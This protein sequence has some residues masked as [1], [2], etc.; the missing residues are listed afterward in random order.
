MLTLEDFIK[1]E[2]KIS[3]RDFDNS[4]IQDSNRGDIK[5]Y[6]FVDE[7]DEFDVLNSR[8]VNKE[9]QYCFI[10]D[11][12]INTFKFDTKIDYKL[13]DKFLWVLFA[14]DQKDIH[15][16]YSKWNTLEYALDVNSIVLNSRE[17]FGRK[18]YFIASGELKCMENMR[19]IKIF[20]KK[21]NNI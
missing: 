18:L 20:I 13:N 1:R 7:N 21:I 15:I 19:N 17:K 2:E 12:T 5:T 9:V 11:P 3:N 10:N 8:G 14:D 16:L 6:K 4:N